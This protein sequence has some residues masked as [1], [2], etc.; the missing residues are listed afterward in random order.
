M[1]QSGGGHL[2]LK[3][4]AA[5][6][7]IPT[8]HF[9]P[10]AAVRGSGKRPRR[11]LKEIL[12]EHSSF[13]RNHLKERLYEAGLK[14]PTCELCGQGELW[15][16]RRMGL[17]LDHANGVSN[18]NRLEK[19]S[20]RVPE[21][22]GHARH[23]LC[24]ESTTYPGGTAVPEVRRSIQSEVREAALLLARVWDTLGPQGGATAGRPASRATAVSAARARGPGARLQ[25]DWSPVR[26][27]GQRGS[28]VDAG[29]TSATL[30]G[31]RPMAQGSG[32]IRPAARAASPAW[33]RWASRRRPLVSRRSTRARR[34]R[35]SQRSR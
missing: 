2:V 25:R 9:D 19:P 3:K 15:E 12:V 8:D 35:T 17:I 33:A 21:L 1:C 23:P 20:H 32:S 18:D 4:Y 7:R 14:H 28:Q 16:G 34:L 5:L 27:I 26:N 11:P 6:W 30:S 22:R 29:V 31:H 10:Y 24:P 13:A